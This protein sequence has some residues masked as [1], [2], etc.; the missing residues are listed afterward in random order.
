MMPHRHSLG[1]LL[2]VVVMVG[3][4]LP[5]A[6]A[7]ASGAGAIGVLQPLMIEKVPSTRIVYVLGH[8]GCKTSSCLR[9]VRSNDA[10]SGYTT[11]SLPPVTS[12]QGNPSG[13][14]G[15]MT[16]ASARDGY[17]VDQ[18][19]GESMLYV[20]HDGAR[21]WHRQ[22]LPR[23]LVIRD[24]AVSAPDVYVVTVHCIKRAGGT[25]SCTDYELFHSD[26]AT[27]HWTVAHIPD[28]NFSTWG[29]LGRPAVRGDKVWFSG[30]V[31]EPILISSVNAGK[32][33]ESHGAAKLESTVG[34]ALT[35]TSST[36]LWAECPTGMFVSLFF[37]GDAGRNWRPIVSPASQAFSG[38]GG[39]AFDPVSGD[40]AYVDFGDTVAGRNVSRVSN[41]G[42]DLRAVG[43][44]TCPD[45]ASLVFTS[46]DNGLAI[47]SDYLDT[48]F[49]R[50]TDGGAHWRRL[51]LR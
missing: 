1:A 32:S 33:F 23:G 45:V 28:G 49:E 12:A 14:L 21:S 13:S 16:F 19:K 39:G 40:V 38:T 31:H 44:L 42:R 51:A 11:V 20:T 22:M 37:S 36:S 35:A 34:C 8:V 4:W 7:R 47:C 24:L 25:E 46:N 10:L 17:A 3:F 48:Y 27:T 6:G 2:V 15:Q 9:L 50:S 26:V 29:Y 41:G 43:R 18:V 5:S 30:Q